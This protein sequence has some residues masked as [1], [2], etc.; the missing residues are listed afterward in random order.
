MCSLIS[1]ISKATPHF[2]QDLNMWDSSHSVRSEELV[3]KLAEIYEGIALLA[4]GNHFALEKR[5]L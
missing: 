3:S 2:L 4:M 1:L 5:T